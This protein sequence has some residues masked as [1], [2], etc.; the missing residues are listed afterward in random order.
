[1]TLGKVSSEKQNKRVILK[2]AEIGLTTYAPSEAGCLPTSSAK[3]RE[4]NPVDFIERIFGV[5]PDGGS[6]ELELALALAVLCV[7][8]GVLFRRFRSRAGRRREPR[9]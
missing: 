5:S 2:E 7:V 4:R 1:M 6:G 9:S 3:V 8:A